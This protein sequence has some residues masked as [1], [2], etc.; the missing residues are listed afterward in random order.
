[1][2]QHK[3]DDRQL[4][5]I[6]GN[7]ACRG[8]SDLKVQL[9]LIQSACALALEG[10][11]RATASQIAARASQSYQIE[12]TASFTGLAFSNF[13]ID[14]VITHGKSRFVLNADKLEAS[15]KI[16]LHSVNR[17]PPGCRK[18]WRNSRA[19]LGR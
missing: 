4:N 17:Q 15:E 3:T 10:T 9:A 1:M 19:F 18:P 7:S 12:V 2:L 11:T 5:V 14:S 13:G 6:V 8:L 16:S